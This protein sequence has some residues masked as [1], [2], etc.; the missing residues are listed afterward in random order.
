MQAIMLIIG[1]IGGT[2]Y[3]L[4]TAGVIDLNPE[5]AQ[6]APPYTEPLAAVPGKPVVYVANVVVIWGKESVALPEKQWLAV[7]HQ[8]KMNTVPNIGNSFNVVNADFKAGKIKAPVNGFV[9]L[10][11]YSALLVSREGIPLSESGDKPTKAEPV[12]K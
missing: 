5:P 2:A 9:P 3:G 4:E 6:Q 7:P 12:T 1:A 8:V 10:Y 11:G